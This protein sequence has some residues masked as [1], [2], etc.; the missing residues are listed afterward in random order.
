MDEDYGGGGGV[1]VGGAMDA[2]G[3]AVVVD[4]DVFCD[5]GGWGH[6]GDSSCS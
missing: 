3:D 2:V 6:G 5:H 4:E 1:G